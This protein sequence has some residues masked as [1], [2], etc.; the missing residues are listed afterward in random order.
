MELVYIINVNVMI[1]LLE[2]TVQYK[3]AP[4]IVLRMV[5]AETDCVIA[6]KDIMEM[7]VLKP[8]ARPS[9]TIEESAR[10]PN[11]NVS[12]GSRVLLAKISIASTTVTKEENASTEI[13]FVTR[14][15]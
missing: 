5:N 8:L 1:T 14:V 2:R 15:S 4:E 3:P 13:V 9:A 7:T 6:E 12:Q 10:I 11:A